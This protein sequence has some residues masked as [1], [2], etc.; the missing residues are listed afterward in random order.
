MGQQNSQH[1]LQP[2]SKTQIEVIGCGMSRTGTTS[3]TLALAHLLNGPVYHGGEALL[4]REESH[5]RRWID[6]LGHTPFRSTADAAF[7]KAGLRKQLEGHVACTDS[8]TIHFVQELMEIYPA[9]KIVCTVRDPDDWWRSMEPVVK[10]SKMG[11]LNFAFWPLPTLRW[12][13]TYVRAMEEG[14]YGELYFRDG[15]TTCVRETYDYHIDYLKR[16]VPEE[17]L[18]FV[19]VK[20]GWAPLCKI[21]GKK[22][23]KEPFPKSNDAKA[24]E[25]FFKGLV[26][27]G[28]M[29]WAQIAAVVVGMLAVGLWFWLYSG[30]IPFPKFEMPKNRY[31]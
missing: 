14:R 19:D 11:F 29:A 28:L 22:V 6:I 12:W 21:L 4:L 23:P 27:R 31:Q 9:A 2:D 17:R 15:N 10:N 24:T 26:T 25:E 16:M 18:H 13:I 1:Q 5:I 30:P 3:F 20:D 7:V 8:P